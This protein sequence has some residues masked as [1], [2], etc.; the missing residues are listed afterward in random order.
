M[1]FLI[2]VFVKWGLE[3]WD[4][5]E[6]IFGWLVIYVY[7]LCDWDFVIFDFGL[8]KYWYLVKLKKGKNKNKWLKMKFLR[9]KYFIN[10][11]IG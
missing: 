8:I 10:K 3:N 7:V 6:D 9:K 2:F 11:I 1:C 5:W 4:V